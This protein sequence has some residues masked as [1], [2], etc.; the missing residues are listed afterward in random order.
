MPCGLRGTEPMVPL[1]VRE[2]YGTGERA[3][4]SSDALLRI[5]TRD[6]LWG[7]GGLTRGQLR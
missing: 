7:K 5:P 4:K 3:E 6:L 1:G 2:S